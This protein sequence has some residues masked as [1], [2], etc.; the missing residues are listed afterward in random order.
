MIQK[1]DFAFLAKVSLG[2]L[3]IPA[4]GVGLFNRLGDAGARTDVGVAY[5]SMRAMGTALQAYY[6][7]EGSFPACHRFNVPTRPSD[8]EPLVLERLTTP[9][10]Y[11]AT[12]PA[13]PF[14]PEFRISSSTALGATTAG[15]T[16]VQE[17]ERP[18]SF[19]YQA[20]N[21]DARFQT[22]SDGFN[23]AFSGAG[24]AWH[25]QSPGPDLTFIT[26]G[27]ILA[28]DAE[29]DGPIQIIYDPTNGTTSFGSLFVAGDP[30]NVQPSQSFAAG[31]GMLDAILHGDWPSAFVFE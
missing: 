13:D 18:I 8:A 16:V 22:T 21:S 20:W 28:N 15:L 6:V 10:A 14:I 3:L 24:V 27:G 11:L 26:G 2:A 23:G 7:D 30:E 19:Y 25:L 5:S 17:A 9:V 1:S 31:R 4:V 29:I 12:L